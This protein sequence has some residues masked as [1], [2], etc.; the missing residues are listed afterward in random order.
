MLPWNY[1]PLVLSALIVFQ[2]L[3]LALVAVNV[4][5]ARSQRSSLNYVQVLAS[6]AN[7]L[8]QVWFLLQHVG[9]NLPCPTIASIGG[10]IYLVFQAAALH[11][12]IQRSTCLLRKRKRKLVRC[13]MYFLLVAASVTIAVSNALRTW[14]ND[15]LAEGVC[16]SQLDRTWNNIGKACLVLVYLWILVVFLV[17]LFRHMRQMNSLQAPLPAQ[18]QGGG[19]QGR[20][21]RTA[22]Q[23][24]LERVVYTLFIKI[25]LAIVTLLTTAILGSLGLFGTYGYIEFSLQNTAVVYAST[26]ALESFA[27]ASASSHGSEVTRS[28]TLPQHMLPPEPHAPLRGQHDQFRNGRQQ[29]AQ[30]IGMQEM[31]GA[32]NGT[33]PVKSVHAVDAI[34][35]A[36][37]YDFGYG[38]NNF[39]H[40]APRE[41]EP[42]VLADRLSTSSRTL[43][44]GPLSGVSSVSSSESLDHVHANNPPKQQQHK[45]RRH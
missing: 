19:K 27:N 7:A 28:G 25:A 17:P 32:A 39:G 20:R 3:S 42:A 43:A 15:L 12:I 34:R 36:H 21:R 31:R 11:V 8:N 38:D 10:F 26:L 9:R 35:T 40:Y 37:Y 16:L 6:M 33:G 45:P 24:R 4:A 29:Q 23:Q 1:D 2:V 14:D 44:D 22:P 5:A 30:N 18:T 41:P 13:A